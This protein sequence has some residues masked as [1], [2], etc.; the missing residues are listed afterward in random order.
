MAQV[1]MSELVELLEWARDE[2]RRDG[3]ED[4]AARVETVLVLL[5]REQLDVPD[6]PISPDR[7]L[8]MVALVISILQ[9]VRSW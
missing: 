4:A 6:R 7:M 5:H 1:H 9:L 8:K 2:F 3:H